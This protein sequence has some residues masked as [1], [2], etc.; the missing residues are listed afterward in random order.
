MRLPMLSRN[1]NSQAV[2]IVP[3]PKRR[4]FAHLLKRDCCTSNLR[5]N[6]VIQKRTNVGAAARAIDLRYWKN[7]LVE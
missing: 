6:S 2:T 5:L 4:R 7:P 1:P 3:W